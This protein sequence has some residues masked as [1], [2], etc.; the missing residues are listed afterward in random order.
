MCCTCRLCPQKERGLVTELEGLRTKVQIQAD[1]IQVRGP[2][3]GSRSSY[4][5]RGDELQRLESQCGE[6]RGQA[7]RMTLQLNLLREQ[8]SKLVAEVCLLAFSPACGCMVV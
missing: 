3:A 8:H 6:L 2:A 7:S 1:T 4:S 5:H